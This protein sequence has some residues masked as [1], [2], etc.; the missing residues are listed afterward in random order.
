MSIKS[1]IREGTY[2][3][4]DLHTYF[5]EDKFDHEMMLFDPNYIKFKNLFSFTHGINSVFRRCLY[6]KDT[7]Y[8]PFV[9][10]E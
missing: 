10:G 3:G 8:Y 4:Q 7:N 9:Y 2:G 6:G 1:T 5:A